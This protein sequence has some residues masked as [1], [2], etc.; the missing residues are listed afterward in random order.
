MRVVALFAAALISTC[1]LAAAEA[2]EG[3]SI[4]SINTTWRL[5]GP[6]DK[7]TI[8]RYDDPKVSG[9]SCY[10]SRA[11]TGGI[12]GGLGLAE[13]PSR[14]SIACR[15]TGPIKITGNLPKNGEVVF[16]DRASILFKTI[17]IWR[18]V[19]TEKNVLIYT[20]TSTKLVNGSPY[21]AITAIPIN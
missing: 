16:T 8:T 3:T 11:E 14:F 17:Q 20:V 10:I 1:S 6:D 9:A 15:A 2:E 21:N 13:D 12:K 19:D 7:I 4:G 18:H 5:L